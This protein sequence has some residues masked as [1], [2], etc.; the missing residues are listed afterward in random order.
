LTAEAATWHLTQ[1]WSRAV[2]V[3]TGNQL[4][5]FSGLDHAKR[6]VARA[7]AINPDTGQSVPVGSLHQAVHDAAGAMLDGS[8]VLIGGGEQEVGSRRV[9]VVSGTAEGK[10]LGQL[11]APRS[12]LATAEV[13][14]TV[15]VVGGYDGATIR[16]EIL[17]TTDGKT[18]TTIGNLQ[19]PVRYPAVAQLGHSI[20]VFGGKT[21]HGQTTAVQRID[22]ATGAV[23]TVA[24]FPAPIGHAQA[25]AIGGAIYIVGG[26]IG[27]G[28][29]D[30][31]NQV[32]NSIWSFDPSTNTLRDAG[33]LPSPVADFA[34]ATIGN[35]VL[36][37][38]GE[39][40]SGRVLDTV[41]ILH[42]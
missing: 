35:R 37:L 12:D 13:A 9:V 1:P 29:S 21:A 10:V 20:Y 40:Q 6:S 30:R 22:I 15:Y 28:S 14:G 31:Q 19:T 5:L 39:D 33:T 7:V 23:D 18:F 41:A 4:I 2:A 32:T 11:P 16:P 3:E 24:Q 26:R 42:L 27:N 38:G 25:V 17:A 36:L 34:I 8:A